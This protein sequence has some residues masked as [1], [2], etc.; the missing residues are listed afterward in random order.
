MGEH[1]GSPGDGDLASLYLL[2]RELQKHTGHSLTLCRHGARALWPEVGSGQTLSTHSQKQG[3]SLY[4]PYLA[5]TSSPWAEHC[6][7]YF[8]RAEADVQAPEP[9]LGPHGQQVAQPALVFRLS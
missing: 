5:K 6:S 2:W 3:T 7:L 9:C 1:A 4:M 8:V